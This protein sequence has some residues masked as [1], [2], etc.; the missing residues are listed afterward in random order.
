MSLFNT[1][2]G[3]LLT[4]ASTSTPPLQRWRFVLFLDFDGVLHPGTSGTMRLIPALEQLLACYPDVVVVISS[5][6]RMSE[7]LDELRAWFS[8][9]FASRIISVTPV[10]DQGQSA[11][12]QAEAEAW[13][14]ENATAHYC[15]VDDETAL[16]RPGCSWLIA[17]NP[18]TGLTEQ[19]LQALSAVFEAAGLQK[20]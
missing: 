10:L 3:W 17:T 4:S 14:T 9:E 19:T 20:V 2:K 12:R 13:L 8:P 6:W 16:F 1:L 15:A 18:R 7:S 5:T 11:A